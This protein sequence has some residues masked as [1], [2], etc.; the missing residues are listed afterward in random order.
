MSEVTEF[1]CSNSA[2]TPV[3]K[4]V[5]AIVS[6]NLRTYGA[7]K[8][9]DGGLADQKFRGWIVR[10]LD[11]IK[12]KLD[13]NARKDLLVSI[14][15]LGKGYD[16]LQLQ[17]TTSAGASSLAETTTAQKFVTLDDALALANTVGKLKI[18]SNKR[19]ESAKESFKEAGM[20]ASEAFHNASLSTEDRVL[21]SKVRIASAI[22]EQLDNPD[23]AATDCLRY[24]RE[25]H[26][27]P[28]IQQIF[29]VHLQGGIKSFFKKETRANIVETI[30]MINLILADFISKFTQRRMAVIDWPMIECGTRVVHPIHYDELKK[31]QVK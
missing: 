1:K 11:D 15:C 12:F 27:M 28:A 25:L 14:S 22:L 2:I 19:F 26:A 20:K 29:L 31:L 9:Q 4:L 7:E 23:V 6:G 18:K 13:A 21:A 24:L 8:L 16:R 3:L 30:T 17:D 5:F 10:E